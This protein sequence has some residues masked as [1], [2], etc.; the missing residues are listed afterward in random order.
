MEEGSGKVVKTLGLNWM[1]KE[2]D[3]QVE[4]ASRPK[5]LWPQCVGFLR[6]EREGEF[7]QSLKQVGDEA[8]GVG[9]KHITE[10][11]T[12][13]SGKMH[14]L[15]RQR[16]GLNS[17][18]WKRARDAG[19]PGHTPALSSDFQVPSMWPHSPPPLDGK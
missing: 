5:A 7:D 4:R 10:A 6:D 8:P 12:A 1:V 14:L 3:T 16:E 2:P 19:S 13:R 18:K 9:R 11:L 17:R 15:L